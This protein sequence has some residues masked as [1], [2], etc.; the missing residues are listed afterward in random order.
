MR[1]GGGRRG[2][3]GF[4]QL[5]YNLQT[6]EQC[7]IKFIE[8]GHHMQRIVARE[9]LN[10]RMC[11]LHPHIV[12]L[13]VRAAARC[14]CFAVPH[15]LAVFCER[16]HCTFCN[17]T[18]IVHRRRLGCT[19][20][21]EWARYKA[22]R[23]QG[24]R[25]VGGRV[26]WP[27]TARRWLNCALPLRVRVQEVFLTRN[28]VAISMEYAA[29][30]DLSEYVQANKLPGVRRASCVVPPSLPSYPPPPFPS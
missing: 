9:L 19:H 23:L 13:K 22:L 25:S 10:Q 14:P 17:E 6:G 26:L 29:G 4:V 20:V 5:A 8:R 1:G 7:A 3:S 28:H 2:T 21:E 24:R 16:R 30:G 15:S 18:H 12:Q 27:T 11:A